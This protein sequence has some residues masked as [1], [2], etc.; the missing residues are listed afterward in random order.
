MPGQIKLDITS[1][2][3]DVLKELVR[4]QRQVDKLEAKLRKVGTT[5]KKTEKDLKGVGDSGEKSFNKAKAAAI[6]LAGA[7]GLGT[8]AGVIATINEG[9]KTWIENIAL[10]S[11]ETKQ[12]ASD[13]VAFAVLQPPGTKAERTRTAVML[14]ARFGIEDRNV[15]MDIV[16]ALQSAAKGNLPIGL[17]AATTVFEANLVGIPLEAGKEAERLG[18]AGGLPPGQLI[19]NVF[20]AGELSSLTPADLAKAA[21]GFKF[22]NDVLLATAFTSVLAD[23]IVP[24]RLRVITQRG[25]MA[26]GVRRAGLFDEAVSTLKAV[27]ILSQEFRGPKTQEERLQFLSDFNIDTTEKLFTF[28]IADIRGQEALAGVVPRM[29]ELLR[30]K[31]IIKETAI[32]GL[33]ARKLAQLEEELPF[34]KQERLTQRERAM[35][36]EALAFGPL[37]APAQ[38]QTRLQVTRGRV[39]AEIGAQTG[40]LG[41]RLADEQG[42]VT[43]FG[44]LRFLVKEALKNALTVTGLAPPGAQLGIPGGPGINASEILEEISQ[45]SKIFIEEMRA[46]K[47]EIRM[48]TEVLSGGDV[49]VPAIGPIDGDTE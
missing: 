21:P 11:K 4:V 27:G 34:T 41:R 39:L 28:G 31:Q 24:E 42:R 36:K 10:V 16:Q 6:L 32:P 8:V 33:F 44:S 49:L 29:A 48:Q 30:R 15:S 17:A 5:G 1:D 37:A 13:I 7:A 14:G 43:A 35:R 38:E 22:F 12:A 46:V 19:R 20:A 47:E 23:V 9:Y 26:L 45:D 18:V 2:P 40:P 25:G 3:K